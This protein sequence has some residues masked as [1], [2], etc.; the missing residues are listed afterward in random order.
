MW[1]QAILQLELLVQ[2]VVRD[3]P[4]TPQMH[5]YFGHT[6]TRADVLA[7]GARGYFLTIV[8]QVWLHLAYR[9]HL[10]RKGILK[11]EIGMCYSCLG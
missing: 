8:L 10:C 7:A 4:T 5:R 1:S 6:W 2:D 9:V 11:W 3:N